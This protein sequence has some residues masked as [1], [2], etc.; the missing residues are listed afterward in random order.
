MRFM[1]EWDID[2]AVRRFTQGDT[3]ILRRA[4]LT[5]QN[6]MEWT[7]RNSDGWC[8][9]RKP[10][11]AAEKLMALIEGVDRWDAVDVAEADLKKALTPIKSFCTR[12]NAPVREI[13]AA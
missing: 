10:T 8:Y 7:N 12:H 9:W 13:V 1:N 3:P 4:A 11:A 2:N 5:L 6:L